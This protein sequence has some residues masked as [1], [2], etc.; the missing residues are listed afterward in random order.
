[1]S[2]LLLMAIPVF[3]IW[4]LVA[5]RKFNSRP[6]VNLPLVI[7]AA[8]ISG[9]VLGYDFYH[10]SVVT[11]DRL[12]WGG[13]L[14]Y[15]GYLVI[16]QKV[17]IPQFNH[18]D[19]AVFGLILLITFSTFSHDWRYKD[20]LPMGRLLFFNL[21]PLGFY[22]V[23]RFVQFTPKD[24]RYHFW[25][26]AL[27][28][29]FLSLL[30][31]AEVFEKYQFVWPRYIADSAEIEFLGRARGP[32]I[33]PIANGMFMLAGLVGTLSLW[34]RNSENSTLNENLSQK[35]LLIAF[36]LIL[37]FGIYATKTRSVWLAAVIVITPYVWR[38]LSPRGRG[39][40]LVGG[41]VSAALL[42]GLAGNTLN[43]FKRDKH[44]TAA[45]TAESITLRPM[46]ATVALD[47][48]RDRPLTGFG[49]GQ[50]TKAKG[51]YHHK[52]VNGA[53]LQ[54]VLPYMQHNLFLS[55]LTELGLLGLLTLMAIILSVT[56]AAYRV[57]NQSK[58]ETTRSAML[59]A[60]MLLAA[61]IC[62]GMFHDVSIIPMIGSLMF[63]WFGIS[64][65][66]YSRLLT[67]ATES[68]GEVDAFHSTKAATV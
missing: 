13:M 7:T 34:P 32:L 8:L 21:M 52:T 68:Y 28:G 49:F 31:T 48:F 18:I 55:Y 50:Y 66:N 58:C 11:I 16:N 6:Q 24:L 1:M 9:V 63:F 20:N 12:I 41:L 42:V 19:C 3:V 26:M 46:L 14:V 40:L 36:V 17:S 29:V 44:V 65:E 64:N 56:Y 45:E 57:L 60:L 39:G 30:G 47:M 33:N 23:A 51:P 53:S 67:G 61:W 43:N 25:T 5:F 38:Q 62:N 10:Q 37:L 27:L 59:A 15:F 35:I 54:K 2:I 22:V 4:T